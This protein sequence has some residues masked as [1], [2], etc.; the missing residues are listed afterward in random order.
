MIDSGVEPRVW[1]LPDHSG[2]TVVEVPR[3]VIRIGGNQIQTFVHS[4]F[5]YHAQY[6][7]CVLGRGINTKLS[8]SAEGLQIVSRF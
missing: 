8:K 2:A 4:H 5:N 1:S 6:V 7:L 3:M